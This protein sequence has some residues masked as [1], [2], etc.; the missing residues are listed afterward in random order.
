M[1]VPPSRSLFTAWHG[2]V[3]SSCCVHSRPIALAAL[4]AGL[5]CAGATIGRR[6]RPCRQPVP[7]RLSRSGGVE[8]RLHVRRRQPQ[9][10]RRLQRRRLRGVA[11]Q[12]RHARGLQH[13]GLL[14][15]SRVRGKLEHLGGWQDLDLQDPPRDEMA[16]RTAG[17]RQRRC[18][19]L[20]LHHP[21]RHDRVL[22]LHQAHRQGRCSRRL[23]A[24]APVRRA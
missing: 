11:P 22:K 8:D 21:E 3:R 23:H 19:H 1:A 16:G 12:L 14:A 5:V 20:Q 17:H 9:P 24:G 18:L 7:E 4:V 13:K 15:G 6:R 2:R 10:V